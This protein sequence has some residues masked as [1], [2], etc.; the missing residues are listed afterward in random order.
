MSI[1]MGNSSGVEYADH[2]VQILSCR[3]D[4]RGFDQ[5][6]TVENVENLRLFEPVYAG[7]LDSDELAELVAM[8]R[9]VQVEGDRPEG[10]LNDQ[11]QAPAIRAESDIGINL[12]SDSEIPSQIATNA[13]TAVEDPADEDDVDSVVQSASINEPGALDTTAVSASPAFRSATGSGTGNTAMTTERFINF[14]E[15]FGSGPY[16]DRT[17]DISVFQEVNTIDNGSNVELNSIYY[18]YWS[19]EEMPEGRASFARP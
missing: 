4:A 12:N 9:V 6:N 14:D 10:L 2:E 13:P 18:L 11:D 8:Y 16:V 1:N 15:K 7:G 5:N 19:V 3:L 17:D